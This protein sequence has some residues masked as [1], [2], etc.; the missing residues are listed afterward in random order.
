[1]TTDNTG[2]LSIYETELRAWMSEWYDRAFANG[3]IQPPFVL[4][5]AT[6][7]RLEGYFNSG[8]TP[9]EGADAIF[10]VMH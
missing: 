5:D 3:F 1:M 10:G 6:A 2:E 8:L 4:S 7:V 9:A